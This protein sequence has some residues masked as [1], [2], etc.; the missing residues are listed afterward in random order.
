MANLS[1]V[2]ASHW[3]SCSCWTDW[4]TYWT[5]T[6]LCYLKC[7][8]LQLNLCPVKLQTAELCWFILG[9][10]TPVSLTSIAAPKSGI[11]ADLE[12]GC[13]DML[14][15]PSICTPTTRRHKIH[16]NELQQTSGY[17]LCTLH[18]Q[19][20]WICNHVCRLSRH[21]LALCNSKWAISYPQIL[22]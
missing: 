1:T 22:V 4:C 7:V 12:R 17:L 8:L 2:W 5:R 6:S 20:Q 10:S 3:A 16:H 18:C 19:H 11:S 21:T 9:F 13:S 15:L 14:S